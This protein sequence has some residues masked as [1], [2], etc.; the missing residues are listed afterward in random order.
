MSM[1]GV[2]LDSCCVL[3]VWFGVWIR[4]VCVL[5]VCYLVS[6]STF[7]ACLRCLCLGRSGFVSVRIFSLFVVRLA[8]YVYIC[9]VCAAL[10]V[11]PL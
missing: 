7:D 3:G 10:F 6:W 1:S 8:L 5:Y 9:C 11:L 2:S 4:R